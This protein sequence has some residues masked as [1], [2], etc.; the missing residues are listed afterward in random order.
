V[1]ERGPPRT[2]TTTTNAPPP[3]PP[4][5][6][7][8]PPSP[9]PP[10]HQ[11][12][13]ERVRRTHRQTGRQIDRPCGVNAVARDVKAGGALIVAERL[14]SFQFKSVYG[15]KA[16]TREYERQGDSDPHSYATNYF[17]PYIP[18]HSCAVMSQKHTRVR[19]RVPNGAPACTLIAVG[20]SY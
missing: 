7:P 12:D 4:S 11:H 13:G 14:M 17:P 16:S 19:T 5:A 8:P 6:A 1:S 3:P 9:P 15:Y 10:L 20:S 18:V 2:T